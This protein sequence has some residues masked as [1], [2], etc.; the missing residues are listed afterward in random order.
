MGWTALL[1]GAVLSLDLVTQAALQVPAL[2]VLAWMAKMFI[3]YLAKRD[4]L[5]AEALDRN[6]SA[7]DQLR[8]LLTSINGRR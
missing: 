8:T 2:A 6:T 1:T 3:N 5:F 7:L 4:R